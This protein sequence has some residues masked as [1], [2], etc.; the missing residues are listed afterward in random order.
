MEVPL[1]T[2]AQLIPVVRRALGV[3][4][5]R[6]TDWSCEPLEVGLVNPA[7]AGLFRVA[8]TARAGPAGERGWRMVL[9]VVHEVDLAGTPLE[10][11]YLREPGDWN[12]WKREV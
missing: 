5:V 9:K 4:D 11:G 3:E 10:D 2:L 7:T 8:G 6:P 12:Y 1:L